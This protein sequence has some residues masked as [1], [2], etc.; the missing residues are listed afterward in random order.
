M[1]HKQSIRWKKFNENL[2]DKELKEGS[3]VL[4]YDNRFDYRK[5]GKLL[6]KWEGPFLILRKYANG[7]YQLQDVQ[8]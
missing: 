6:A 5:D 7:S 3:L 2:T 1:Q 8:W 4:R